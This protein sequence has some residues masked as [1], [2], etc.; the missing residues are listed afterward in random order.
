MLRALGLGAAE[1]IT[2]PFS[3]PM[4]MGRLDRTPVGV[5]A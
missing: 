1:L 5:D 2:K 4:L 3:I